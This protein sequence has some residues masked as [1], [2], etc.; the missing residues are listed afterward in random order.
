MTKQEGAV[1]TAA[2]G[3]LFTDFAVFHA[4]AEKLIGKPIYTHEFC[5]PELWAELRRLSKMDLQELAKNLT[6]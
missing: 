5:N 6:D 3:I 2:T 4:Y 1:I